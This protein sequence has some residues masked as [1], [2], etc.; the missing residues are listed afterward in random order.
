MVWLSFCQPYISMLLL[1]LLLDPKWRKLRLA[2]AIC[3]YLAILIAGSIP[4]ARAEIGHYASGAT[5]HSLA[6]AVL[7][8]LW[9]TSSTGSPAACAVKA[10]LA[11]AVMGAGDEMVQSFFPY[12]GAAVGDWM[13]DCAAAVVT[14]AVLWA[15]LPRLPARA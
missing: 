13:V 8:F 2:C 10:V 12:R 15:V 9:F 14:S 6:Y 7:A 4:G 11:V 1:S 5:L 3:M